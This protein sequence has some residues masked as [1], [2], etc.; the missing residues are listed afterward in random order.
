MKTPL[1]LAALTA[2]AALAVSAC[3]KKAEESVE[4]ARSADTSAIPDPTTAPSPD[5]VLPAQPAAAPPV[6]GA[7]APTPP[8]P[9]LPPDPADATTDTMGPPPKA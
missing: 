7:S 4:K 8:P 5:P 3:G 6:D 1:T 2:F 9:T